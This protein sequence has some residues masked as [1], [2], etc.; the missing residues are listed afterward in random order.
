M[1]TYWSEERIRFQKDAAEV[2]G[3]Y[4]VLATRIAPQI[5]P[6]SLICDAGC[7][8][9][10][11]SLALAKKC[12]EIVAVDRSDSALSVLKKNL[13]QKQ[14]FN[15]I[16]QLGDICRLPIDRPYDVMIFCLFGNTLDTLKII[17]QQ[18]RSH[19]ILIKKNWNRHRF[20]LD[21]ANI[22]PTHFSRA[23]EK[24]EQLGI[25]YSSAQCQLEMGQPFRSM[26]DAARF[27]RLYQCGN[28]PKSLQRKEIEAKLLR[29]TSAAWP[30][31]FPAPHS[32]GM[33]I[34]HAADI[35]SLSVIDE[36]RKE[37]AKLEPLESTTA[38]QLHR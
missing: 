30:Y 11:L 22:Y 28:R 27:F 32:V 21:S 1:N 36:Y 3:F 35:P 23:L 20:A 5:A 15:V 24:L 19:A 12:R 37:T 13:Q 2:V 38:M 18:C 26:E 33:I 8:L 4:D 29:T 14:I 10:Y 16:P 9:G 31:F 6:H 25:H 7:G 34:L 17:K